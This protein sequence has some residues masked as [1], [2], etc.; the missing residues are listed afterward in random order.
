VRPFLEAENE[1][2]RGEGHFDR[3]RPFPIQAGSAVAIDPRNGEVLALVSIPSYDPNLFAKGISQAEFDV[4][5]EKG[6][7][8]KEQR[9][10]LI[11]RAISA[12]IPPGSTMKTFIAAAGLQG[13]AIK[14]DT[15]FRC[16]GHIQIEET[17]SNNRNNYW[18]WTRDE[19]HQELDV[20]EALATSCDVFF[21][22][23]GG[24]RQQDEAGEWTHYY[25]PN[26][27][28]KHWFNGLGIN[29]INE[30]L[31]L[32]GFGELSGIELPE[33]VGGVVPGIEWKEKNI[34]G[35]WSIGDTIVTAIGQG[36]DLATP[37]QLCNAT[38]SIANGGTLYKPTLVHEIL[39][40]A[41]NVVRGPQA[42]VIRKLPIAPQHIQACRE[43][44]RM[45][46]DWHRPDPE[47]A[48]FGI[49]VRGLVAPKYDEQGKPI[50]GTELFQ[51]PNGLTAGVKTGTA[52]YGT[53]VDDRGLLLRAHAWCA[54][55][56]PYDNPEICVVAFI[57]GGSASATIAAPVTR[58]MIAAWFERKKR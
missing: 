15:K 56:A 20:R 53:E 9:K 3:V 34:G 1:K 17:W 28:N 25:Q 4:L 45:N 50:P 54:A 22:N 16:R 19:Q 23:V 32:F 24:P 38:A 8:E 37:L 26:D 27:P 39:D 5:L 35:F 31:N 2:E 13:G 21:Y 48:K 12:E 29:R 33:E 6:V 52:E 30:Y 57:E 46:V 7:P 47:L 44:M 18:C 49:Q 36:Y 42:S 41:G 40:D 14:A 10:P 11:N 51:L 43:G 55:F 58:D